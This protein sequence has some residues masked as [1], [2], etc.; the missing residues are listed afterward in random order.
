M[1]VADR[2]YTYG[3]YAS[4]AL[5][6]VKTPRFT[7]GKKQ[8]ERM[9]VDWSRELYIVRFHVECIMGVLKQKF[10]SYETLYQYH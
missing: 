1:Q 6:E 8:L 4:M 10:T 7:R 9:E 2:G 3:H 5:A